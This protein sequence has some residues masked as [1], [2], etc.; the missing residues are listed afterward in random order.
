MFNAASGEL[1]PIP[2]LPLLLITN[3][4][5]PDLEAVK[6]SPVP[7]WSTITDAFV[8]WPE[9]EAIGVVPEFPRTSNFEMCIRDRTLLWVASQPPA[10]NSLSA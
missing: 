1:V 2:T 7:D 8:V 6:R 5:A 9:K 4:V 3:L 10:P